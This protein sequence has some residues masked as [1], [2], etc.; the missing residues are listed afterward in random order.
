MVQPHHAQPKELVSPT[1]FRAAA[2]WA[3]AQGRGDERDGCNVCA[4]IAHD[5]KFTF[6]RRYAWIAQKSGAQGV[7][8][9][10]APRIQ[11]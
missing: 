6:P 4:S 3:P 11:G 1:A 8:S 10:I 9:G 2:E 5:R 7:A